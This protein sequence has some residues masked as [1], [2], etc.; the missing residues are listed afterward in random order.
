MPSKTEQIYVWL[1][2]LAEKMDA[3]RCE[4]LGLV[5]C[6]GAA[7]RVLGVLDR[8]TKDVDVIALSMKNRLAPTTDEFP[9]G[10]R[11]C[12]VEV[13]EDLGLATDWLNR[14]PSK[15]LDMG[16]P[17]GWRQRVSAA[18]FGKRLRIYWLGRADLICLKLYAACDDRAKRP[19]VHA[20]DLRRFKPS[21]EELDVGV[22]WLREALPASRY[23]ELSHPLKRLLGYLGHEDLA[24]YV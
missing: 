23:A 4:P 11:E 22:E 10:F 12:V 6:G 18:D 24:Y 5:V 7:L 21:Y 16:L 13:A 8:P 15:L 19:E 3:H 20:D 14:G 2:A 9:A 17:D 1:T